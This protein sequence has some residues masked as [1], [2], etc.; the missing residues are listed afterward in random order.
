[1]KKGL[2]F[3]LGIVSFFGINKVSAATIPNSS[4]YDKFESYIDDYISYKDNIDYMINYWEE[5][6]SLEYPY[7]SVWGGYN[8]F[9]L[10]YSK[11]NKLNYYNGAI[12]LKEYDRFENGRYAGISYSI[13]VDRYDY[14]LSSTARDSSGYNLLI[15][16]GFIYD[17]E[18]NEGNEDEFDY[19]FKFPAYSSDNLNLV[20]PEIE[21][22][23]GDIF[24]TI[25]SLYD[26]SYLSDLDLKYKEI[27]LNDYSYVILSLKDYT[28]RDTFTSTMY[29]KGQ[30]CP[31][32]VY[33]YGL[34]EKKDYVSGYQ[35]QP[36][37]YYYNNFTRFTSYIKSE[38]ILNHAIYYLTGY[39]SS[40]PN[41]VQVD[42]SVYDI[43]Y[44]TS[45]NE[46]EPYVSI[47][48][49]NYPVL[50]YSDLTDTAELTEKNGI[51][52]TWTC[53]KYDTNCLLN[54]SGID[55]DNLF[56]NPLET[57]KTVWSAIVSIFTLITEFILLL[58]PVMQAFL[59]LAFGVGIALGIIKILL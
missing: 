1:M 30:L 55:I 25:M 27:N 23:V 5:N 57:L 34:E 20:L 10:Y 54:S 33:N 48:G 46:K 51:D 58:P 50:P 49:K 29:V 53:A 12:G 17:G 13:S 7:Y 38:D 35:T 2:I 18:Y 3:L 31:T 40:K 21:V 56:S 16:N 39:D 8:G 26:G 37:S 9:K 19:S 22:F 59:L 6:Y 44:I 41:L 47:E 43:T 11:S 28:P 4:F 36:C 32:I 45:K 15:S 14:E 52:N 42:T 24:P